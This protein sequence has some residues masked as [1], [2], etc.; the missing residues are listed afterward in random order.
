MADFEVSFTIG[1]ENEL[2]NTIFK[3][4]HGVSSHFKIGDKFTS[5]FDEATG[6]RTF[7]IKNDRLIYV[8]DIIKHDYTPDYIANAEELPRD[9]VFVFGSNTEGIHGTGSARTA[10]D[11]FGAIYGQA[12]GRQGASYAI[13]T[14]DLKAADRYPLSEI[15]KH[16]WTFID[17][18]WAHPDETFYV[19]KI[20]SERAGYTVE[21]IA[22]LW[23]TSKRKVPSN[24]IMPEVYDPRKTTVSGI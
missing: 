10:I 16:I 15:Q 22:T 12:H 1:D 3:P 5:F 19:T 17:H 21:E 18:A 7:V 23:K 2:L 14:T 9:S 6:D 8:C 20:G 24:V 13:C 11:E 4:L